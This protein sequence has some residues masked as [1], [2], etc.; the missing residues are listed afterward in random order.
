MS[1]FRASQLTRRVFLAGLP[2]TLAACAS[3]GRSA[4]PSVEAANVVD[5]FYASMYSAIHDEPF[6]V[7]A[8]DVAQVDP[9]FLRQEVEFTGP[10]S[11]G[12]IVVDPSRRFLY[13]VRENGRAL[14][15]GCGVGK[16]GFDYQGDAVIARKAE[17]PRWTPTQNMIRREPERYGPFAGGQE[18]GL[19]NPLGAR[20]LYLF[21]NGRDT[22]Y[23]IHGTNE[24]WS[25][26]QSVSSGCI[27]LFNQDIIDLHRRVPIGTRV[28]VLTDGAAHRT[29]EAL[30]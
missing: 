3:G 22:L 28:M 23:R 27:R 14:R 20:A 5:P 9:R 12:E 30:V 24:P 13:L 10:E 4:P 2:L 25:I 18:G 15:Y 7:P 16:A 26:G 6:P 8:I 29:R 17:W 11:P 1:Q 21:K 19:D